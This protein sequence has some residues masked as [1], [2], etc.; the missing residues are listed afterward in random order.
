MT[1][2]T[3]TSSSMDIMALIPKAKLKGISPIRYTSRY[4]PICLEH[5]IELID[6]WSLSFVEPL[7][8]LLEKGSICYLYLS[9]SLEVCYRSEMMQDLLVFIVFLK[10]GS[11]EL[12]SIIGDQYLQDLEMVNDHPPHE[13]Y[14]FRLSNAG[15]WIN[16]HPLHEIINSN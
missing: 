11:N 10:F 2:A 15:K 4:C 7:L 14:Y 6:P 1:Y 8:D 13:I 5:V 16:F 9:I 3:W 12:S